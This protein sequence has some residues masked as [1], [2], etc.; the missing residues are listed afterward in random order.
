MQLR[1]LAETTVRKLGLKESPEVLLKRVEV[2][3]VGQTNVV[4]IKATDV[5]QERAAAIAN[6]MADAYVAWSRD[7]KR[8]SIKAA[9]DEVQRRLDEARV[10]ILALGKK[11]V[12]RPH[13]GQERRR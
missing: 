4:T 10:E 1:P 13:H 9:A 6:S 5:S 11:I 12:E 3:A 2:T 7:T 8:E